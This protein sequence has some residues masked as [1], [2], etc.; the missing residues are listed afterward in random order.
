ML[1]IHPQIITPH[2][3]RGKIVFYKNRSLVP[4]RLWTTALDHQDPQVLCCVKE[5]T[6]SLVGFGVQEVCPFADFL[7][8]KL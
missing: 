5:L 1:L 2:P 8:S 6:W 4:K 3:I 7:T